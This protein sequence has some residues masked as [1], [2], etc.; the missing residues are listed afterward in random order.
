VLQDNETVS[1]ECTNMSHV[2]AIIVYMIAILAGQPMLVDPPISAE[3]V[4]WAALVAAS[5]ALAVAIGRHV[6]EARNRRRDIYSEAYRTVMDWVEMV[7]R[8]RRRSAESEGNIIQHAHEIQE[9]IAYHEG[10]LASESV[11]LRNSY[12]IF[13]EDVKRETAPLIA[14]AWQ[15][16]P[17]S[18]GKMT[19]EGDLHPDVGEASSE[20]LRDVRAHL[21]LWPPSRWSLGVRRRVAPWWNARRASKQRSHLET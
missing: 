18:V 4:P 8:V 17:R 13:V 21:A 1:A 19:Q 9:R 20:F 6:A 10:W 5:I 7:Y 11:A 14:K 3:L 12:S 15:E 16:P 2:C